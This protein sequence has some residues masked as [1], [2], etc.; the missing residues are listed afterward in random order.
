M[1]SESEKKH[2]T[3]IVKTPPVDKL[4]SGRSTNLPSEESTR[5][6]QKVFLQLDSQS[7]SSE[8]TDLLS[9]VSEEEMFKKLYKDYPQASQLHSTAP[10][11][12]PTSSNVKSPGSS[13]RF[14]TMRRTRQADWTAVSKMDRKRKMKEAA[15]LFT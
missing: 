4:Q 1:I 15:K 3:Y 11:K 12:T 10:K 2:K 7:D 6:K 8:Y 5:K 13:L 14:K 9:I